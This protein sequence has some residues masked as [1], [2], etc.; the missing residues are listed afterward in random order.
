MHIKSDGERHFETS[1]YPTSKS[2][3]FLSLAMTLISLFIFSM[4]NIENKTQS[5]TILVLAGFLVFLALGMPQITE[6]R[7]IGAMMLK[8][9][10]YVFNHSSRNQYLLLLFFAVALI[11]PFLLS[12]FLS[13]SVWLGSVLGMI[14]GFSVSQLSMIFVVGRWEKRTGVEL[15]GYRLW[16]YDD[17]NRVRVIERGVMRKS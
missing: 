7:K 9:E 11:G 16:V 17:E 6:F 4:R 14:I 3:I 1:E 10:R 2:Q 12:G 8:A 5:S 15:E 13:P